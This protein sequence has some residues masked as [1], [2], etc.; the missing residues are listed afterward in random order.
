MIKDIFPL[1]IYEAQFENYN[2]IKQDAVDKVMPF[3]ENKEEA[4]HDLM[5]NSYSIANTVR[6]L[7]KRVDLSAIVEFM[8]LHIN[9][10]WQQLGYSHRL[11]PYIL[12][13]WANN[14]PIGGN[15]ESHH[16]NPNVMAGVFYLNASSD[17]GNLRLE[18]PLDLLL[19]RMPWENDFG[20]VN[21]DH[22]VSINDGKL[23]LFPGWL[24]HR[25]LVNKTDN[26]RLVIGMNIGCQGPNIFFN[27][28]V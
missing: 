7:H 13:L 2:L 22:E 14:I 5:R 8:E 27:E 16:H 9:T 19:G 4:K 11:N 26:N 23:V 15:L 10:Y 17:M 24:K 21:L 28:N 18:N 3:F 1:K 6:D 25:T 20:P 12:H